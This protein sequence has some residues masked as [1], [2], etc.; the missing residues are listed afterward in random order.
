VRLKAINNP[1]DRRVRTA[2][3][4]DRLRAV[5][6]HVGE[7]MYVVQTVLPHDDA[8]RAEQVTLNLNRATGAVEALETA[9]TL[10]TRPGIQPPN[11]TTTS[12]T[13]GAKSEEHSTQP[14]LQARGQ[15][16]D[17]RSRTGGQAS[18][19]DLAVLNAGHPLN[20]SKAGQEES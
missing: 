6:L 13:G 16:R 18:L 20:G 7:S 15:P 3:V 11:P 10:L 9:Q 17:G 4:T 19:P 5:L 14:G 2:R 1:R 12:T 8:Y